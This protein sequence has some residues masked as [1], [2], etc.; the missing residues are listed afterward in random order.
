[1]PKLKCFALKSL[2]NDSSQLAYLKW[3]LNNMN[4]IDKLKLDLYIDGI[5]K[6]NGVINANFVRKYCMADVLINLKHFD[7]YLITKC[8]WLFPN[9][10]QDIIDSF[11][12]DHFFV[13]HHWTSIQC[14]FDPIFSRQHISSTRII[15]PKFFNGV[16]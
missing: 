12:S 6:I 14:V 10:I 7:F 1:M 11:K 4:H 15:K 13:D 3:I 9:D 8:H 2:I 16:M 5:M